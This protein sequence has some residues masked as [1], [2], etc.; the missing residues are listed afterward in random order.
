MEFN[1]SGHSGLMISFIYPLFLI[2]ITF[3][4]SCAQFSH[5]QSYACLLPGQKPYE[6]DGVWFYPI[7]SADGYVED[8][9]ASW[10]G[11][12]FHNRPTSSGE[13]YNM[14]DMTAAHKTLPL[15]TYVKVTNLEN[16]KEAMVRINDRGPFVKGRII[17][18]SRRAASQ[19]EMLEQGTARVRVEAVQ[20]V[21]HEVE[22]GKTFWEPEPV[23]NFIKGL[24]MVQAGAF[25][26]LDN[27][28]KAKKRLSRHL[29][30][31][32]V[33]KP[34]VNQGRAFYRVQAGI[35]HNLL[36]ARKEAKRL[37]SHGFTDVIVVAVNDDKQ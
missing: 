21:L 33:I 24:F 23:P 29:A 25:E 27:A 2:I 35:F 36:E 17:D 6:I 10:Y 34:T 15:G 7:K 31:E 4:S 8:G 3:I 30:K 26:E 18:L 13:P 5:E 11:S 32:V 9:I 19:L 37:T 28:I 14:N 20:H 22:K 16:G 1:N 12:E